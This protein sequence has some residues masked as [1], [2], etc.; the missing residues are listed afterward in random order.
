MPIL[1][2]ITA[3]L[4]P[5]PAD[6]APTGYSVTKKDY[7]GCELSLGPAE[8]DGVVPMRAECVWRDVKLETFQAQMSNYAEHDKY[9][10]AVVDSEVRRT[11]GTRALVYQKHRSSGIAD[12]EVLLWMSHQTVDGYERYG[13]THAKGEPL[14]PQ[15][16]NVATARD[17]GYWQAKPEPGG[18]I[19][20]IHM[21]SYGPG[22]SVPG[23]IV[24]WFQTSGLEANVTDLHQWMA[25][26]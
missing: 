25:T 3:L 17:D 8:A 26:H 2:W 14:T 12:R 11:E 18:G 19:R 5:F 13:W 22:G 23:F 7:N 20:V 15:S 10:E 6:A 9:F 4:F 21:L 1:V 24:R 16:G